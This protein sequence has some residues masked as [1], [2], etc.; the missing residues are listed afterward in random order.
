MI[1][2]KNNTSKRNANKNGPGQENGRSDAPPSAGGAG[3]RPGKRTGDGP[4][5]CSE[6][7]LGVGKAATEGSEHVWTTVWDH[8]LDY[9]KASLDKSRKV[10]FLKY[11]QMTQEPAF[12]LKLLAQV[13]G[14]PISQEEET[15]GAVDEILGLCSFD[16]L[17][18]LEV[19]KSETWWILRNQVFFRNGKVGDWKNYLTSEMAERLEQITAQKFHGSGLDL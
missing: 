2:K 4:V 15:A 9:W 6:K 19:N 14:C 8:V 11:E 12:Y 17:R 1:T 16:H 7:D 5:T 18:N 10:L 3:R 13:L